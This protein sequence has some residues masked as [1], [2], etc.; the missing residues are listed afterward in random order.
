MPQR[1]VIT[2][3][4]LHLG[5]RNGQDSSMDNPELVRGFGEALVNGISSGAME[6]TLVLNG[7]VFDL[8]EIVSDAELQDGPAGFDAICRGL[9]V[10][11][12]SPAKLQHLADGVRQHLASS[13]EKHQDFVTLLN[14]L[15][16]SAG[17]KIHF[18]VGNHDHQL[19][20]DALA[21]VLAECLTNQGVERVRE[22]VTVGRYYYDPVL[23]FY[24]E[25][26][27]QFAG[28]DSRVPLLDPSGSTFE[29]GSG[30]YV[31]RYVWNR[32]ENQGYGWVQHPTVQQVVR[33]IVS[34][35]LHGDGPLDLVIA[36]MNDYCRGK[37]D[38]DFP[39]VEDKWG[40]I[41]RL[42]KIW[43]S[44]NRPGTFSAD[45]QA[46]GLTREDFA[47]VGED[48][49]ADE[50]TLRLESAELDA[51]EL[52]DAAGDGEP[53]VPWLPGTPLQPEK[54]KSDRYIEGMR[55]RFEIATEPFPRLD[56]DLIHTATIGHT[57]LEC[58]LELFKGR[59]L[60][61]FNSGS[62]TKGDPG[63]RVPYVWAIG[64]DQQR[65]SGIRRL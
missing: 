3:S 50:V 40:I 13:L 60:K 48:V 2:I 54:K 5:R 62:W 16:V 19:D 51:V 36:Y 7:D 49:K 18:N 27:D 11:T 39:L 38:L 52:L 34:A 63:K 44:K 59:P 10:P 31:L 55:T 12:D 43:L 57:H 28:D 37:R 26:G 47:A 35:V 20:N 42:Y 6:L 14:L 24:A 58:Q 8:W 64:D 41:R 45:A 9:R 22:R 21:A 53:P 65:F 15:I 17:A 23:Q 33:M 61:F 56:K 1:A 4:D 32:L 46:T 25:H 29:E 30:F